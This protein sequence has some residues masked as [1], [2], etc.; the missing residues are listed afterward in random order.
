LRIAKREGVDMIERVERVLVVGGAGFLGRHLVETLVARHVP[1][2][3]LDRVKPAWIGADVEFVEGDFAATHMLESVMD[4]CEA[5]VHLAATTI[6]ATSNNDPEFDVTSNLTGTI[7]LLELAVKKRIGN[8]VF[9]SSGGTV[10]GIPRC[11]PVPETAATDPLCSYG[12][13]K[14]AIEKY[15]RLFYTLHGLHSCSLRFSNPYGEHQRP[16]KAQGVV[17]V[18]CRN[19]LLGRPLRV[20][21]DGSVVRDYIYV[22]DMI[23]ALVAALDHPLKAAAIN[24]G[25]GQGVS[26]NRLIERIG[27]VSGR[28]AIVDYAQG[29]PF[30]VPAIYL[31]IHKARHDLGWRPRTS[32]DEGLRRTLDWIAGGLASPPP[33]NPPATPPGSP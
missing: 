29:R 27:A 10:Y 26:I 14:L 18:F 2:R 32:L 33:P 13:V 21:G 11:V 25:T 23:D 6:P 15:L 22:R 3:I 19:V 28:P 30:D 17:A 8:F 5:V 4:S 24:V 20:W 9:A 16:D 7:R 1:V 12:I 31:D